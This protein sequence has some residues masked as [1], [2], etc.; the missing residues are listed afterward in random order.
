VSKGIDECLYDEVAKIT[1]PESKR[2]VEKHC[3]RKMEK[4]ALDW[5][6]QKFN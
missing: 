4:K 6:L 3:H 5:L 1:R 2:I